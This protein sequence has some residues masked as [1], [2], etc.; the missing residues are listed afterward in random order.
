VAELTGTKKLVPLYGR[1]LSSCVTMLR[2]SF[3]VYIFL[4]YVIIFFLIAC[5]VG[6]LQVIFRIAL[7]YLGVHG[8]VVG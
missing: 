6:S 8:I 2:G 3:G 1:C 7:V 5:F 4:L